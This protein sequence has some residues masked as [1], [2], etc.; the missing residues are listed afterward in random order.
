MTTCR[1]VSQMADRTL[2]YAVINITRGDCK[3]SEDRKESFFLIRCVFFRWI[4]D[5]KSLRTKRSK[6][7]HQKKSSQ[8]WTVGQPS[9][10]CLHLPQYFLPAC[11]PNTL[12]HSY[13]Y[14]SAKYWYLGSSLFIS[15][16]VKT[17]KNSTA[18][19]VPSECSQ[20]RYTSDIL[21]Y[22]FKSTAE[23]VPSECS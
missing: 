16:V 12:E 9:Q 5:D 18:E 22:L 2:S 6:F 19:R 11:Y 10:I 7:P 23:R 3:I 20:L 1:K 17:F 14:P 15:T 21:E 13:F 8:C 4:A